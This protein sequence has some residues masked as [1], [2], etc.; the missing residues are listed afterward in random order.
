MP[1]KADERLEGRIVDAAYKLW[2]KGGE[3]ALTMRAV[4][5]AAGT[6]T[7]TLYERFHDKDDL[8]EFLRERA[9]QRLFAELQPAKTALEVCRLGLAFT[10]RPGNEYLLFSSDWGERL[11]KNVPMPSYD[12]L[13]AKLAQELGGRPEDHADLGLTLIFLV[14]GTAMVLQGEEVKPL[15]S[16]RLRKLCLDGCEALIESARRKLSA[17]AD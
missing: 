4:A 12:F 14:H 7:P 9:R 15:V 16:K 2:S 17:A 6:S 8:I 1:R 13:K 3:H 10:L 11:G 5:N